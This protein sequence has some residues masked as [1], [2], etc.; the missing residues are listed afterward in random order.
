MGKIDLRP[1]KKEPGFTDTRDFE[2]W[3]YNLYK[4][5]GDS[6]T[7]F[8]DVDMRSLSPI[9][10]MLQDVGRK[11]DAL[12]R[13]SRNLKS[14]IEQLKRKSETTRLIQAEIEQLKKK[15]EAT[16]SI[17]AQIANLETRISNIEGEL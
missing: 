7:T 16:R 1:P 3:M 4:K 8:D 12:Q 13:D 9:I 6:D 10:G 14:E 17:Q 2:R 5:L 11:L 15:P